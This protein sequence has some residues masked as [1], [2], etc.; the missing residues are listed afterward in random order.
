M[1]VGRMKQIAGGAALAGSLVTGACGH[2]QVSS[3]SVRPSVSVLPVQSATPKAPTDSTIGQS[4]TTEQGNTVTVHQYESPVAY[5]ESGFVIAAADVEACAAAHPAA[6][7]TTKVVV[8]PGVSPRLFRLQLGD[9]TVVEP[10]AA[11]VKQPVLP[12]ELL[13]AG[14][15]RRGWVSFHV[16]ATA[17][18]AF[19]IL[20]SLSSIRWR[21]Q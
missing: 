8:K 7:V 18:G 20:Q 6:S 1:R 16:P 21:V 15:C 9:G 14:S 5:A 13:P 12:E 2:S 4:V 3:S 19:V 17:K 10:L 11:G